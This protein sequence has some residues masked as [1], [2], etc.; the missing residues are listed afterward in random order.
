MESSTHPER[1]EEVLIYLVECP[2]QVPGHR[3]LMEEG[4]RV[5]EGVH[6]IEAELERAKDRCTGCAI[7]QR[8][9]TISGKS[10]D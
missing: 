6:A 4:I 7:A 5:A 2:E 8:Q 9:R 3:M 1:K 10:R